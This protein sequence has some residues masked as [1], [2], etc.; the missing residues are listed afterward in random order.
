MVSCY[1]K[2]SDSDEVTRGRHDQD[3]FQNLNFL[4]IYDINYTSNGMV[5]VG[6]CLFNKALVVLYIK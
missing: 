1:Y 3:C 6:V 2:I 5:L 4:G